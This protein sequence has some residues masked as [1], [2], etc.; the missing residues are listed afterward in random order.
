V[1][2]ER[3]PGDEQAVACG[4][5]SLGNR[6]NLLGGFPG[7]ED[8]FRKPLT[9]IAMVIDARKTEIFERGLAQIL[10]EAVVRSLRRHY[11]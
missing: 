11:A 8:D 9:D 3:R 7:T 10:K 5:D 4:D 1:G 2:L 6:G